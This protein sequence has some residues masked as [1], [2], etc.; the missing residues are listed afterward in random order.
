MD[1]IIDNMP[2]PD[3]RPPRWRRWGRRLL[4]AAVVLG[5]LGA[6]AAGGWFVYDAHDQLEAAEQRIDGLEADRRFDRADIAELHDITEALV[7]AIQGSGR[8]SR[9]LIERV[10]DLEDAL[11]G[12][13]RGPT[14]FDVIGDL[15]RQVDQ[16]RADLDAL[17]TTVVRYGGALGRIE[18]CI[19]NIERVI[20]GSSSFYSP[21][22]L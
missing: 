21:C 9:N 1:E 14:P 19:T 12:Y 22:L 5:A 20:R 16:I 7:G 15:E 3:T 13:R 11:F 10:G 6:F 4:R 8:E 18:R 2:E 17:E